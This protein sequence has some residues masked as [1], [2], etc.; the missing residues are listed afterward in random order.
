MNSEGAGTKPIC[1][2]S[3]VSSCLAAA[4]AT[5]AVPA[6]TACRRSVTALTAAGSAAWP[7]SASRSRA[8]STS[9]D[10]SMASTAVLSRARLP[11]R[12]SSS[13]VSS[14][15][16]SAA[17]ASKPN[18]PAPPLIECA[19]RNTEL[20]TSGSCTPSSSASS[21]ASIASSPSRLS[22]K[23]VAWKRCRSMLMARYPIGWGR[24]AYQPRTFCTVATSCSGLNGLT[25]QPVAPAAL[26]SDFLS[27]ADSVVSIS[28]GVNL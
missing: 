3:G 23:K 8:R 14:T 21:P 12:S 7:C 2:A 25:S 19:A 16:V 26:P 22:S 9:T 18:V 13:R 4:A 27:A 15:W 1:Q 6:S 28:I 24:W 10:A 5:G 20:M 17:I 11:A